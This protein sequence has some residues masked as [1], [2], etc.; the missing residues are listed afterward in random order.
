MCDRRGRPDKVHSISNADTDGKGKRGGFIYIK[1]V[2]IR[3]AYTTDTTNIAA[4][5]I[6][7]ALMVPELHGKWTLATAICSEVFYNQD[8]V[9]AR[10]LLRVGFKQIKEVIGRDEPPWFFCFPRYLDA[11]LLSHEDAT[12]VDVHVWP[13]NLPQNPRGADEKLFSTVKKA[14]NSFRANDVNTKAIDQ[15]VRMEDERMA[16]NCSG[17]DRTDARLASLEQKHEEA[18]RQLAETETLIST[19]RAETDTARSLLARLRN[20][21][22][23][24]EDL[25]EFET[26]CQETEASL[27]EMVSHLEA[28]RRAM[29]EQGLII[30]STRSDFESN[31]IVVL[32]RKHASTTFEERCTEKR[33]EMLDKI[34]R[35]TEELK[36]KVAS[37]V[38]EGA[39]VRRAY[40]LHCSARFLNTELLDFSLGLV[41]TNERTSAINDLDENG[42]TPLMCSVMGVSERISDADNTVQHLLRIGADRSILDPHGRTALGQY[43]MSVRST[44]DYY[45]TFNIQQQDKHEWT[46]I[47]RRMEAALMPIGGE[48]EADI[49]AKDR[50]D[51]PVSSDDDDDEDDWDRDGDD[52]ELALF[53]LNGLN[54]DD[55][56]END[57]MDEE[58]IARIE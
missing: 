9:D 24:E 31:S 29:E 48:T 55:N 11:P 1:S 14:L 40:V 33:N 18:L 36:V 43:R 5:A 32:F 13:T 22:R 54:D 8:V 37:L 51:E 27:N 53:D 50:G 49:D 25:N 21:G 30:K 46:P 26:S 47:H 58:N 3:R 57:M 10:T 16:N 41:P 17:L 44:N 52:E 2:R 39:S 19:K 15:S 35:N 23:A 12:Q 38:N 45:H 7:A 34:R 4:R 28:N 20:E 6:Q 56:D 42:M